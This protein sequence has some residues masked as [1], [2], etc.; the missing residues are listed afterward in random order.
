MGSLWLAAVA[1]DEV[2]ALFGAPASEA[3]ALRAIAAERFSPHAERAPGLL[4]KLGPVFRRPPDAP[5]V[6]PDTPVREDCDRILGGRHVPPHRLAASWRLLQ[7][8]VEARAWSSQAFEIDEH[9]LNAIEFDLARAGVSARHGVRALLIRDLEIGMLPAPGMAVGYCP[10]DHAV[11]A[12]A[13]WR[14]V[15][16]DLEPATATWIRPVL[17]WLDG[18]GEWAAAAA[19]AQR[20]PPD[21][22]GVLTA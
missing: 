21:L 16:D 2:R 17:R 10:G 11:A 1:I 22:I 5:V 9:A 14:S 3:A 13:A 7:V 8:W 12:A 4:G 18:F 20:Q 19:D 6:R 15:L